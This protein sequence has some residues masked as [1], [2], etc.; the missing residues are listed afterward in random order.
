MVQIDPPR[1]LGV[2][3]SRRAAKLLEFLEQIPGA[4]ENALKLLFPDAAESLKILRRA[5]FIRRCYLP[6]HEP[7]FLPAAAGPPGSDKEFTRRVALGWLACW[8]AARKKAEIHAGY[9]RVDGQIY[10][11]AVWPGELPAEQAFVV[12]V[13]GSRAGKRPGFEDR[14]VKLETIKKGGGN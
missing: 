1:P 9:A 13:D 14:W 11:L 6:D 7:L 4:P 8:L 5:G 3:T 2:L 10:A 12:S